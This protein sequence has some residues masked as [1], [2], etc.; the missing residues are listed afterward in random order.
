MT[1]PTVTFQN[2][3][4]VPF[5]VYDAFRTDPNATPGPD[6]FFGTLTQLATVQPNS[7]QTVIPIHGP[8]STYLAYDANGAPIA[9]EFT[10]GAAPVT[11]TVDD[12][13]TARM[14]AT[15]KFVDFITANPNDTSATTVKTML[16]SDGAASKLDTFFQTMAPADYKDCTFVSYVMVIAAR[17]RTAASPSVQDASYSMSTLCNSLGGSWPAEFPDITVRNFT[18]SADNDT[19]V[20]SGDV[21]TSS[22]TFVPEGSSF[23]RSM[24]PPTVRATFQFHYGV[25]LGA[26]STRITFTLPSISLVGGVRLNNPT[27]TLDISPIFRFAVLTAKAAIPFSLF[28]KTFDAN[29]SMVVDN[30]EAEVA[31]DIDG[32]HNS[33]PSPPIMKGVHFDEF[34]VGMGVFFDPPAYALGVEGKFHIGDGGGVVQLDDDDFVVVCRLDGDVPDPLYISFYV[35]SLQLGDLITIFTDTSLDFGIPIGVSDLSFQWAKNPLEPVALPDGSLSRMGYGFSGNLNVLG[36]SFYG[37]VEIDAGGLKGTVTMDPLSLGPLKLTGNGAGVT[38]KVDANGK[39]IRNNQV[40]TT[41]AVK[42]AIA[43]ATTKQL[44]AP[45][46]PSLTVNTGSS[47]YL[48]LGAGISLFG[49]VNESIEATIDSDGISFELDFGVLLQG[50]MQCTLIDYHNFYGKFAFGLDTSIPLPT[51][52][53]FSLGSV[54][55]E[56][57]CDTKVNVNASESDVVLSV[58]GGFDFEG[59]D[60]SIGPFTVDVPIGSISDLIE[61]IVKYVLDHALEFFNNVIGTAEKWAELAFNGV[62]TGIRD[63]AGGLK[64]AFNKTAQEVAGIMSNVG[65]G[66]EEAAAAIRNAFSS[67]AEDLASALR[68]GYGATAEAATAVLRNVG[69]AITDVASALSS[70]FGQTPEA[71]NDILQGAGY[72]ADEVKEAFETLG[73][74]FAKA[75]KSIWGELKHI[76]DPR[77]W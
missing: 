61:T 42:D 18:C 37:D 53:G 29:V 56:A 7:T 16:L 13:D 35:P 39:P 9:R 26:L 68:A 27:I 3:L 5:V 21:D 30:V 34:G 10:L 17:A 55:L 76:A 15:E 74:D 4:S 6:T 62:I 14:A 46:G 48:S 28:G 25:D 57:L 60:L 43:N 71:V 2:K 49:L 41:K 58:V 63:V 47:P 50:T 20:V 1:F 38:I 66:I 19:L 51:I 64:T 69:Y 11:L 70:V 33:L 23:L 52:A 67:S 59:L 72:T 12:T 75:A 24:L 77:N 40:A 65:Y 73:G 8:I 36:L 54:P 32:D 22:V 45:G 31:V 44:V